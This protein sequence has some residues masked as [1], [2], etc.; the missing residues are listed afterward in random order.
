[1]EKIIELIETVIDDLERDPD[2]TRTAIL[3][4]LYKIKGEAEDLNLAEEEDFNY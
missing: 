4:E 3:E 2:I 1:M